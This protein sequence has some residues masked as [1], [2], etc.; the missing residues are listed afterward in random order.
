MIFAKRFFLWQ[1]RFPSKAGQEERQHF[2]RLF[3]PL[4]LL[5]CHLNASSNPAASNP[6][7]CRYH[8]CTIEIQLVFISNDIFYE[9]N[10]ALLLRLGEKEI[11]HTLTHT[12]PCLR[13]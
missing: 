3:C 5:N 1:P 6:W 11:P 8:F 4:M 13:C 7:S 2:I 12:W 10:V 9:R